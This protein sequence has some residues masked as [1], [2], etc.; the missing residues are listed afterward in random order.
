MIIFL[1]G[2][3][4]VLLIAP[5]VGESQQLD[6][7][8]FDDTNSD[9]LAVCNDG[10]RGGYYCGKAMDPA[11]SNMF[12]IH[13]PGGGQCYD[14]ASC[15]GR[16]VDLMTSK[17]FQKTIPVD[18]LLSNDPEKTP[19]WGANKAQ[20]GYCSSDGYMGDAPASEA[21]WGYHFRGQRLVHSLFQA[22]IKDH[23]FNNATAVYLTGAS[24]GA[25]GMMTQA[26]QLVQLYVPESAR[27]NVMAY[28]D[29][30]YYLDVTPYSPQF[31]GFQYQEQQ[32]Y[33]YYN[34]TAV[35][36]DDCI[37]A[38]PDLSE[39]WKCQYGQ[40]RMP[41][42]RT[43]YFLV[44]SQYD[45]YQLEGNT[46][47]EPVL[48]TDDTTAYAES[49][50]ATVRSDLDTLATT[51]GAP[52][53]R[54]GGRSG[55]RNDGDGAGLNAKHKKHVRATSA[56]TAGGLRAHTTT[57]YGNGLSHV[58]GYGMLSWACYNHATS[59][60]AGFYTIATSEGVTQK[61]AFEAYLAAQP[62]ST[63]NGSWSMVWMDGCTT[64]ACGTGCNV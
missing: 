37:A 62:T 48:Y 12:V 54:T 7:I 28:L 41:F 20:L 53:Y 64:F 57:R 30:P 33:L 36:S 24:A 14:Q 42:V 5:A 34:T 15:D 39:Q 23:N 6:L 52:T 61:T 16:A 19:L 50:G 3:I 22:L 51:V 1:C 49:F 43:P 18:G 13:L 47:T 25:R 55:R 26:D 32:K 9:P 29:S 31:Q 8:M 60:S 35:L 45:A 11:Q 21:T 59:T 46:Q 58:G 44:A 38:Y 2:L 27:S 17:L 56:V 40:Y 63:T 10:S 4:F